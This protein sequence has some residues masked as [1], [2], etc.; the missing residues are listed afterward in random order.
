MGVS[1]VR[2]VL[3][4]GFV[5]PQEVPFLTVGTLVHGRTGTVGAIGTA[6]FTDTLE[7]GKRGLRGGEVILR[8]SR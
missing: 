8:A 5:V 4:A 2:A 3:D 6:G 7:S 1:T